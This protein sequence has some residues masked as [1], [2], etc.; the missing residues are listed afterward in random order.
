MRL[1]A[2]A[3]LSWLLA[4]CSTPE[5]VA[6]GPT[7]G[8]AHL[9][10]DALVGE[11][12]T[13]LP[14]R[15]TL[16]EGEPKQIL[17][18]VHGMNDYGNFIRDAARYFAKHDIAT[19][20][21]D[22]RGFGDAPRKGRWY[23]R[24][25]MTDDLATLTRLLADKYP[26]KPIYVLGES[27]GGAVTML[28][29]IEGKLPE[30]SGVILSAPAVWGRTTMGFVPRA[31]LWLGARTVPFFEVTGESLD[32]TPSDNIAMLRALGRDPLVLKRTRIDAIFG[33]VDMMDDALA[34]A[35]MGATP[36]LYLYGTKDEIIPAAPTCRAL[37]QFKLRHTGPWRV[38]VYRDGYHMLLRDLKAEKVWHDIVTWM[39]DRNAPLPSGTEVTDQPDEW[40]GCRVK[41][42]DQ[43]KAN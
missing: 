42:T 38:A 26:G 32:I 31:S 29:D 30:V 8:P 14:L 22:Q 33:L 39:N 36:T 17:V 13:R 18:A 35:G 43:A 25:T 5:P 9:V 16:P 21:Y 27:M 28:A 15:P 19:L 41:G 24:K 40:P 10:F 4:A 20:A 1:A 3:L 7:V 6:L 12:G 34:G 11:D 37:G 2:V 23:G